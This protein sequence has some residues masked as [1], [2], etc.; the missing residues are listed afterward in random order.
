MV[1]MSAPMSAARSS[2][3]APAN[4]PRFLV[5]GCGAIGGMLTAT[6]AETGHDVVAVTTNEGIH[7]A[8]SDR[9]L[10]MVGE[11]ATRHV[12]A[13][14]ELGVPKL[15]PDEGAFDYVLL[16][17]QPPQV[18]EAAR[19]AA[20]FLS[21]NGAMVCLQNGLCEERI[22]K[23]VGDDRVI[24]GV[25][26]WGATMPEPGLYE[27][28][29]SGG[30]TLG[31]MDGRALGSSHDALVRALEAVG[32]VEATDNLRGKR[33][34]K[35]AINCAISSLGTIG[36]DRLGALM[37]HR[38][39]RRL[40]LE[41]M[42]EVTQVAKKENVRLEKVSGTIDLSWIALDENERA[43]SGSPSLVAKHGLLLA[44][45]FRYRR[46]KSSMLSAIERG[47]TPA[48]DFLNG[49][50]VDRAR[51]HK[52]PVAVNER[53]RDTVWDIANGKSKPGVALLK[54]VYEATGPHGA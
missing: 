1:L 48:V 26:A 53:I 36:G 37:Q 30:F 33:W 22:A 6:L 10:K 20:P 18:E 27:R 3:P 34:S 49:E 11:G 40:A 54:E 19:I 39:V 47:R 21:P 52:L 15:G 14:V 7:A 38:F 5:M 25:V 41:I 4:G 51:L 13:R 28:T 43:A 2:I 29:A 12:R 31:R 17:T 46:M 8:V 35:L 24:G 9:G 44:V 50:V 45:G 32:P 16:A 23:I 42:T